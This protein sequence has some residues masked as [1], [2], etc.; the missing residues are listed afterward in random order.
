MCVCVGKEI[1]KVGIKRGKRRGRKDGK[2]KGLKERKE[3]KSGGGGKEL[4]PGFKSKLSSL[5]DQCLNHWTF[6]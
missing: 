1:G 3:G 6:L 5:V 2:K 4:R